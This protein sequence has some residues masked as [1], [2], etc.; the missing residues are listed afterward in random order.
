MK[1]NSILWIPFCQICIFSSFYRLNK[2]HIA[3]IL[4]LGNLQVY[5]FSTQYAPLVFYREMCGLI[6]LGLEKF[7]DTGNYIIFKKIVPL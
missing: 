1:E 2:L 6:F 7:I 3:V 5:H 4:H